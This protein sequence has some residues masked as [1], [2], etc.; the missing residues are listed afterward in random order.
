MKEGG[1][2]PTLSG[3]L[4]DMFPTGGLDSKLNQEVKNGA[5]Y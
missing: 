5:V 3:V 1:F 4:L 2:N